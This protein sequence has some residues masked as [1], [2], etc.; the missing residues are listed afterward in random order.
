MASGVNETAITDV[1]E[2]GS[3][4]IKSR[5]LFIGVI[6]ETFSILKVLNQ[7]GGSKLEEGLTLPL[8]LS[9]CNLVTTCDG[10]LI[11]P[12][13]KEDGRTKH[14]DAIYETHIGSYLGTPIVLE[15]G[16]LFGTLCAVDPSPMDFS[17]NEIASMMQLA[18][19]L[20]NIIYKNQQLI[21]PEWEE[22]MRHLDKLALVG[23]LAAGLAHEIRNP[24]QSVKGF[25]QFLFEENEKEEQF[26]HIV[27]EELNRMN[28]LI[29][30]FL[31]ITQ[32]SA[33][34]K[35]ACSIVNI[36]NST[37]EFLR[38]EANLYNISINFNE[39]ETLPPVFIDPSQM[40]QVFLNLIKNAME[41]IKF[42]GYIHISAKK[43]NGFVLFYIKDSGPGIPVSIIN[44]IGD[45]FFSTKEQGVGLGLSICQTIIKEHQ[46]MLSIE[47]DDQEGTLVVIQLPLDN[48]LN[49]QRR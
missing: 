22:K 18:N 7:K 6:D 5:T 21:V 4:L 34:K 43:Q 32:P 48:S 37:I 19:V 35:E 24:M 38:S 17:E 16:E 45:P 10:Q 28:Q 27:L 29:N 1:L 30:D 31:L 3:R 33:P 14:L 42:N 26:K 25:I 40:R 49:E 20:A 11:I 36:M 47:N 46:G 39:E 15:N 41:A 2:I 23:Q 8:D 44:K 12:N 13:T 9:V